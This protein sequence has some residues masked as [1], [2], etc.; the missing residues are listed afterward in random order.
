MKKVLVALFVVAFAAVGLL[1][2]ESSD[3][4]NRHHFLARGANQLAF[5]ATNLTY[6]S[7]G[8]VIPSAKVV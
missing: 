2:Q 5:R 6:H 3:G 8:R 4:S 1:A 7:G